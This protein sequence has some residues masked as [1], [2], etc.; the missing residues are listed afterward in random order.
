MSRQWVFGSE[1]LMDTLLLAPGIT[2]NAE[3][4]LSLV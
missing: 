4:P 1:R 2:H 3:V